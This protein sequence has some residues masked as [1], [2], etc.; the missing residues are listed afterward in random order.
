MPIKNGKKEDTNINGQIVGDKNDRLIIKNLRVSIDGKTVLH[1]INLSITKGEIHALMGPNG[2]GKSTLS[3]TL[4]GHPKYKVENGEVL[5]NNQDILTLKP[6]ERARIGLFLGFQYPISVPGVSMGNFLRM[7]VNSVKYSSEDGKKPMPIPKFH[8]LIKEKMEMLKMDS[9]FTNRYLN[10]GFSGG[11]KKKAEIL[12][13]AMLEPQ[14]AI[15]DETDSG[16]DIDSLKFVSDGV[17]SLTGPDLGVLIITHYKRILNY[18]KPG[19]VHVLYKGKIVVSGGPDLAQLL[20][21]Q[22]YEDIIN[23]YGD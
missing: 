21:D 10:D 8:K 18:I 5:F 22:G 23:K 11:E 6:D 15:L 14:I 2:S 7:A 19:F 20:E 13:M 12:Q 3:Y 17:N 1:D 9:S 16:L 4:M